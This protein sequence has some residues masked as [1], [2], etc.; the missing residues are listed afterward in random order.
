MA[1][2]TTNEKKEL[3]ALCDSVKHLVGE[4]D[5]STCEE[6]IADAM[7]RYPHAPQPHNLM[8]V[9]FEIR[10]DHDSAGKHFRAA[11][12]LDPTY[13]PA[14]YNLDNFAS[15]D[16]Q[17]KYAFDENDYPCSGVRHSRKLL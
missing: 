14:R 4:G 13:I 9:L 6:I 7:H 5:L 3:A 8:G 16:N 17:R 10:N 2:S 15:F 1:H 12:S 11:W